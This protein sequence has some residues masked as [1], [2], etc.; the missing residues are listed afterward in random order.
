SL[1]EKVRIL[2]SG[3]TVVVEVETTLP[4]F[5]PVSWMEWSLRT[6]IATV[7]L[8]MAGDGLVGAIGFD[9]VSGSACLA[10]ILAV[11]EEKDVGVFGKID[12]VQVDLPG[13]VEDTLRHRG[14][15]D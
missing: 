11:L 7:L 14:Q 6:L 3:E 4:S 13:A 5:L 12:F 8:G 2:P 10:G 9:F 1:K 15:G